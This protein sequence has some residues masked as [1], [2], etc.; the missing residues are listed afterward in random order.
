MAVKHQKITKFQL[1]E[2]TGCMVLE[3]QIDKK[4]YAYSVNAVM[5]EKILKEVAK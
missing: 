5:L 4:R 3:F 1:D 2:N